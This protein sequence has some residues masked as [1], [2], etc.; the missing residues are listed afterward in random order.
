MSRVLGF[1]TKKSEP[2]KAN[3][4]S[5]V[6]IISRTL[7]FS[8]VAVY[9]WKEMLY[10][11]VLSC[12]VYV[13]HGMFDIAALTIPFNAVATLSTALGIYLG[14]KNNNAYDRWWEARQIWGLLVNYSRAFGRQVLTLAI[15]DDPDPEAGAELRGWQKRVIYRHIAFVHALR[16]FLRRKFEYNDD[17]V[18]EPIAVHN[19]Y[20]DLRS[21]L[22]QDELAEVTAK[23][24]P[25]NFLNQL[26]G[27]ALLEGYRRGWLSDFRYL[28]LEQSLVEFNNHQ[29]RAERIK[30]TPFPR[31]YSF[32]SRVFVLIHGTLVPFAFIEELTWVNIPLSITINFVFFALDQIGE[33]MEDPFENRMF[34]VPLTA[35]S[36]AIEENLK[37]MLR[38]R[39]LPVKPKPIQ[40]VVL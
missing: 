36:V 17:G 21:F 26:Q 12:S 8:H 10:F 15:S 1:G 24:N 9:A 31:P 16:V 34:D 19:S 20:E 7:R 28:R 4:E 39:D 38:E 23:R 32:Y 22:S 11:T 27:E 5:V 30:N 3:Q 6:M 13:L 18:E 25:P 29:G 33:K 14:F 35:I 2:R 37:E 40:G